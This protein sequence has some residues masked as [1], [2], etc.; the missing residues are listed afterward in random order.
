MSDFYLTLHS[1]QTFFKGT[2]NNMGCFRVYLGH[3]L[4]LP[5]NWEVGLADVFYPMTIR[6]MSREEG[7]IFIEYIEPSAGEV[8]EVN[9]LKLE[10]DAE[11]MV[12]LDNINFYQF[13][14][15]SS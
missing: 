14:P 1:D 13:L 2:E 11:G 5:G 12:A 10:R 4:H 15:T 6:V 8:T 7:M 3:E 9:L